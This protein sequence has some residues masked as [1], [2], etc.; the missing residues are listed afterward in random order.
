MG[1]EVGAMGVLIGAKGNC[2]PKWRRWASNHS[3]S[4]KEEEEA[5]RV[6]GCN[7]HVIGNLH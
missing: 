5:A 4:G 7:D 2:S 3:P 6:S 1:K